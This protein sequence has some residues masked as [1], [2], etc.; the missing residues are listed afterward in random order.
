MIEKR[1]IQKEELLVQIASF[2]NEN[3]WHHIMT[4]A[5]DLGDSLEIQWAFASYEEPNRIVMFAIK[6]GYEES[7]P[8][9][10]EF[11]PSA[12]VSEAEMRDMFGVKFE[13]I[14]EGLFLE[15]DAPKMPLRKT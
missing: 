3:A 14:K 6:I 4:N 2:Y 13:G 15:P 9:L 8:S 12:W 11:I 7:V 5:L 10:K 1:E